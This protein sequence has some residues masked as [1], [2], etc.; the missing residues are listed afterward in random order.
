MAK[1]PDLLGLKSIL[2]LFFTD[3]ADR[4]LSPKVN[5]VFGIFS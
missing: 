4:G 3:F 1:K 5:D 2:V